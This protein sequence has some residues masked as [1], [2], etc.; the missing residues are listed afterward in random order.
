MRWPGSQSIADEGF[1]DRFQFAVGLTGDERIDSK[2]APIIPCTLVAGQRDSEIGTT[3]NSAFVDEANKDSA[4]VRPRIDVPRFLYGVDQGWAC[5]H[6]QRAPIDA[7]VG[8]I[9]IGVE[10]CKVKQQL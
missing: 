9:A 1:R 7:V 8:D 2:H 4:E 10:A 3:F 5:E 6:P